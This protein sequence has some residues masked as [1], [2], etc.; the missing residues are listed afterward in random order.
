MAAYEE[1][2]RT[3]ENELWKWL[4]DRMEMQDASYP[5]SG[6]SG[7]RSSPKLQTRRGRHSQSQGY[8]AKIAE[9]AMNEREVNH[10]IRVTEEKLEALKAAMQNKSRQKHVDVP[11]QVQADASGGSP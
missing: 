3:E 6:S 5:A 4:E 7:Y 1:I 9:E 2:W 10:A 8:R 11:E